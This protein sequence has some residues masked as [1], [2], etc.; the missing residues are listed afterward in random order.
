[1]TAIDKQHPAN[2][3]GRQKAMQDHLYGTRALLYN[4]VCNSQVNIFSLQ[5]STL[6]LTEEERR[7]WKKHKIPPYPYPTFQPFSPL[8]IPISYSSKTS[9]YSKAVPL[10]TDTLMQLKC[11]H[12]QHKIL[13]CKNAQNTEDS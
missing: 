8:S 12:W 11:Y 1:M 13:P 6:C 7:F 4:N 3:L 9:V 10:P 5:S 2:E